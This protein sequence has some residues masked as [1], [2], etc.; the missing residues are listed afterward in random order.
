[1]FV[2]I[3]VNTCAAE[4][5]EG[6][7]G[8]ED[9]FVLGVEFVADEEGELL[10]GDTED[11]HVGGFD[12]AAVEFDGEFVGGVGGGRVL[13]DGGQFVEFLEDFEVLEGALGGEE[14]FGR[15]Q[16]VHLRSQLVYKG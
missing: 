15:G 5:S 9:V 11:V 13:V 3:D 4:G 10:G 12:G 2:E 6:H 16:E 1:M 14:E 8:V 7:E